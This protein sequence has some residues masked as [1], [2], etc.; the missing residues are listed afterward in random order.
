MKI[1][2]LSL[3]PEMFT[4]P[5][6]E[7]IVGKAI[8]KTLIEVQVVNFRDY[9]TNRQKHVDDYPYGGGAGMLLQA[10]PIFSALDSGKKGWSIRTSNFT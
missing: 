9:T 5:L 2:I 10:Q 6:H 4:G 8:E 1:N 7:S 3:F